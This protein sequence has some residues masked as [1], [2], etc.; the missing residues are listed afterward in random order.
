MR[1]RKWKGCP[2]TCYPATL[3]LHETQINSA[4]T[5]YHNSLSPL[6]L[7]LENPADQ[8]D[9]GRCGHLSLLL[10]LQSLRQRGFA[11]GA[12]AAMESLPVHG[13]AA[14]GNRFFY[15]HGVPADQRIGITSGIEARVHSDPVHVQPPHD[16]L[17]NGVHLKPKGMI[18]RKIQSSYQKARSGIEKIC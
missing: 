5:T 10:S 9:I 4:H 17:D 18:I 12:A 11:P 13:R 16:C 1:S 15:H 3:K 6:A 14:T 2:A 8:L 7:L